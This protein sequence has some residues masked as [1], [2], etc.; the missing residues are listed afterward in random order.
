MEPTTTT[1][2]II[3]WLFLATFVIVLVIGIIQYRKAKK[4]RQ[5][6]HRSASA[7][8]NNEPRTTGRR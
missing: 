2:T 7:E 3:P 1:N 6:H 8:A 5:E 4:A